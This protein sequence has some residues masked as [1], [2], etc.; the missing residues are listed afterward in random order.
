MIKFSPII[1]LLPGVR[2]QDAGDAVDTDGAADPL[3]GGV[4]RPAPTWHVWSCLRVRD[5]ISL[6]L[7]WTI[8]VILFYFYLQGVIAKYNRG[9]HY[10]LTIYCGD[11]AISLHS[12][13]VLL[14][15]WSNHLLPVMRD[16]GSIPRRVLIWNRDSPVNVVSL[17]YLNFFE[18][19]KGRHHQWRIKP[20]N[21][22]TVIE[23]NSPIQLHQI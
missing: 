11:P 1:H 3:V 13:T 17:Q 4:Q 18:I 20:V 14:V 7:R 10:W 9:D 8:R 2:V 23:L 12:Y 22:F 21:A 16:L 15:Q 6:K 5:N 19:L